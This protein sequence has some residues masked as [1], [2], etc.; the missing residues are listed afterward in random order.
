MRMVGSAWHR[1]AVLLSVCAAV[2]AA[3]I[4]QRVP[5]CALPAL[6]TREELVAALRDLRRAPERG[7]SPDIE[8]AFIASL[9]QPVVGWAYGIAV[10]SAGGTALELRAAAFPV[11]RYARY[12]AAVPALTRM[13]TPW[14]G[15]WLLWQGSLHALSTYPYP[16]LAPF[17]REM[18]HFPRRVV[19]EVALRGLSLT[20]S[21]EDIPDIRE[22]FHHED[23][24]W[25]RHIVAQA[26]SLLVLPVAARG[27]AWF[28]WP[29]D[30]DGRF[31]PSGTW[32]EMGMG[33][34]RAAGR[35]RE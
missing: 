1:A 25:S 16:E 2:P 11:L 17:W 22:A 9:G 24:A 20:G 14:V 32:I 13:A 27:T 12:R 28:A 26:E 19:R 18:L 23:D 7:L 4:A 29:P 10:D 33:F 34:A 8:S 3:A 31:V 6:H 5:V 30:P 35:C 21:A 15:S